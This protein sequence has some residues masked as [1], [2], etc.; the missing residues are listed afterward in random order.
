VRCPD[1]KLAD[2]MRQDILATRNKGDSLGGTVRCRIRNP[3]KGLGGYH[4][5]SFE[6]HMARMLF[7]IPAVKAV[8]FGLGE[9]LT[10]MKGSQ[11]NDPIGLVGG[12]PRTLT[13]LQG[14]TVGGITDGSEVSFRVAFK[15]TSS[16]TIPQPTVDLSTGTS[17][18]VTTQG[19]HDPCIVPRA[20]VVVENAAA[21]VTLDLALARLGEEGLHDLGG[22]A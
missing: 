21:L 8:G 13:N 1:V 14:G 9:D 22:A 6:S 16:L 20:V 17:T 7:G 18:D 3:P 12:E 11:T 4:Q 10:R 2:A 15:P 19:R 5:D